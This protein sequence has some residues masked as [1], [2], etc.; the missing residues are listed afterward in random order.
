VVLTIGIL[1]GVVTGNSGTVLTMSHHEGVMASLQWLVVAVRAVGAV[2]AGTV[3]GLN[4]LAVS[5]AI[6]TAALGLG[7]WWLARA[8]TGVWT[9]ATLRPELGLLRRTRG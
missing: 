3:W 8:R 7:S 2:I 5:S 6:A 1:P 9:Q 4:G